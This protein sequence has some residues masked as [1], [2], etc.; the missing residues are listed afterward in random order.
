MPQL[1]W[2]PNACCWKPPKSVSDR[3]WWKELWRLGISFLQRFTENFDAV[4][5]MWKIQLDPLK[6]RKF[7]KMDQIAIATDMCDGSWPWGRQSWVWCWARQELQWSMATLPML[8]DNCNVSAVNISTLLWGFLCI[9]VL[10]SQWSFFIVFVLIQDFR[11]LVFWEHVV[12][13][14]CHWT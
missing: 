6:C 5:T 3:N 11:S 7:W 13:E 12:Q 2:W 10:K 9:G 4:R 8:P 1:G 14:I